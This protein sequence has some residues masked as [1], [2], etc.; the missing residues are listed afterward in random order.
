[1]FN[2]PVILVIL[3]ILPGVLISLFFYKKDRTKSISRKLLILCLLFGV[4]SFLL[5]AGVSVILQKYSKLEE[6]NLVHQMIRAVVFVGFVEEGFKFIFLR[7]ILFNNSNFNK[8]FD[9]I[10]FSGLIGMGFA[11]SENLVYVLNSHAAVAIVRMFTAFPAHAI[12][13]IIMGFFIGEAKMF[14]TSSGLYSFLGLFFATIAHGY[15]DYYLFLD[16]IPG[17]WAQAFISLIVVIILTHFTFKLRKD[18]IIN[19]D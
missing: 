14:R 6:G 18:E 13:A 5:S 1:M 4:A 10:V 17:L 9:G 7:G 11:T 12:F 16:F 3:A 8:P 2:N 15:Y 19:I